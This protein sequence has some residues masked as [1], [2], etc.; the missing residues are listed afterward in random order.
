M[1]TSSSGPP[2][3]KPPVAPPSPSTTVAI[4][5][6]VGRASVVEHQLSSIKPSNPPS[7]SHSPSVEHRSSSISCRASNHLAHRTVCDIEPSD[8]LN[9]LGQNRHRFWLSKS[10]LILVSV[11]VDLGLNRG[12]SCSQ[13]KSSTPVAIVNGGGIGGIRRWKRGG[14][15]ATGRGV[16][17]ATLG[18]LLLCSGAYVSSGQAGRRVATFISIPSN[19]AVSLNL[20][21]P[22]YPRISPHHYT[23]IPSNLAVKPCRTSHQLT[24]KPRWSSTS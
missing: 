13:S 15:E 10:I 18:F 9:H 7:P 5:P 14:W 16:G 21:T 17:E 22:A 3:A 11:E 8:T 23:S 4:A 12:R 1:S 19:F 2:V 6:T 20:S 24:V